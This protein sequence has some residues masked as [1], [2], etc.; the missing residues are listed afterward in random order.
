[1]IDPVEVLQRLPDRVL[2]SKFSGSANDFIILD[3][4]AGVFSESASFLAQRLCARRYSIGA[5]GLILVENSNKA[6][7]RVRY[8]NPDG[9]EFNTCGNGGRCAARFAHLSVITGRRMTIETNAGVIEAEVVGNSVKIK[10]VPPS[11]VQLYVPVELDHRIIKGHVVRLGDPHFVVFATNLRKHSIVPF[12]RRLRYHQAFAPDGT[13]V[14]FLEPVSRNT[15]RIRSY[16]RGVETETLACGSGCISSAISLHASGLADPPIT[17]EPQSGIPLIV[18][19]QKGG[20]YQDLYLEGDARLVYRGEL[21][22]EA[23]PG[24]K[25]P[26]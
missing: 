2:F 9:G 5:D 13:N 10:F 23:F 20:S 15:V 22:K 18:H 16:E 11:R 8:F 19:F 17:F 3:N 6:S 1:M 14:H 7:V 21:T 12:A 4:R 25:E 24:F 26:S